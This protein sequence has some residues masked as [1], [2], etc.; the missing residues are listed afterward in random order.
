[1]PTVVCV[2]WGSCARFVI[3]RSGSFNLRRHSWSG[4]ASTCEDAPGR[5]GVPRAQ[6]V[7][8]ALRN[9]ARGTPPRPGAWQ[10]GSLAPTTT[11][12]P[13]SNSPRFVAEL[14]AGHA[15]VARGHAVGGGR[16]E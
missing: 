4:V 9:C 5:G 8:A 14:R 15:A 12:A 10:S 11:A 7:L 6:T 2:S 16:S 1:M 13:C 3:H